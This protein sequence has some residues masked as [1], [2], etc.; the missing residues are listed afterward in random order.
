MCREGS[1]DPV[2]KLV[3]LHAVQSRGKPRDMFSM[4]PSSVG[5]TFVRVYQVWASSKR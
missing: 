1:V 5:C 2:K 4:N 3:S